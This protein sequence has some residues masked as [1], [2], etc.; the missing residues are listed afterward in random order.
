MRTL[1][2]LEVD[3]DSVL[4]RT[5]YSDEQAWQ[6]TLTA[7]TDPYGEEEF[8]AV[9]LTVEDPDWAGATEAEIREV[10]AAEDSRLREIFVVDAHALAAPHE[11][12]VIGL[13]EG[14]GSFRCPAA[15]VSEPQNNLSLAN[16]DFE[17]FERVVD[18]SGVYRG[19]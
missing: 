6:R 12:L 19:F 16:L 8:Q 2:G 15:K 10:I 7:A 11:I 5:D 3:L 18:E 9:F 4:L 17:D 14:Q 13:R 1:R